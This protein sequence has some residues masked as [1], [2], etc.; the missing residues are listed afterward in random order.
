MKETELPNKSNQLM[1]KYYWFI[2]F[3][4]C[5]FF[6]AKP[7]SFFTPFVIKEIKFEILNMKDTELLN[8]IKYSK[9]N[10]LF[11]VADTNFHEIYLNWYFHW[12]LI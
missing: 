2:Y 10:N 11:I 7:H 12:H 5:G 8:K 9:S 4:L 6:C 3:C 1:F